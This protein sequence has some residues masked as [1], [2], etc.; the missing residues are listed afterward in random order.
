MISIAEQGNV[1]DVRGLSTDTKPMN[2]TNGSTFL[3]MNTGDVY[4]FNKAGNAWI[5]L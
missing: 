4:I 2:L 1:Y 5:K 3:E